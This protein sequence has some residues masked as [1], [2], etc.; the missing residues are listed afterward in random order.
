M[1]GP[2][3]MIREVKAE[4]GEQLTGSAGVVDVDYDFSWC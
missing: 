3:D 2:E 4:G 1:P